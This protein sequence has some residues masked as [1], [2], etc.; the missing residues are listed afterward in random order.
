MINKSKFG[1]LTQ[2][3]QNASVVNQY[4]TTKILLTD[5]EMIN[6]SKFGN[7]TQPLQNAFA[8]TSGNA[9]NG[10]RFRFLL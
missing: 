4:D 5:K 6:K 8:I 3:L 1:N 2:P 7:L 9:G 10:E